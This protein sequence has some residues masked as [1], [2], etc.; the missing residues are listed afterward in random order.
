MDELILLKEEMGYTLR[1]L[2]DL[3]SVYWQDLGG[4]CVEIDSE[5]VRLRYSE[6]ETG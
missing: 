1:D 5:N 4:M 3:A 2:K 6:Y